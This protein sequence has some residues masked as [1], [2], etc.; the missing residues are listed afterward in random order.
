[1][2]IAL[3]KIALPKRVTSNSLTETGYIKINKNKL[4][5]IRKK[6][7]TRSGLSDSVTKGRGS[8]PS[9]PFLVRDK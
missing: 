4:N 7:W 6:G 3:M 2:K 1:M 8:A 5:R 9:S